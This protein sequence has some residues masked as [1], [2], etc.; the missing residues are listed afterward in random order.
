[1]PELPEVEVVR[2][3]LQEI[4]RDQPILKKIELKRP[5]LRF[6]IPLKKLNSL[7]GEKILSV[8]RRAKYLLLRT[9]KGSLISHL[10]MTGTWRVAPDGDERDHDHVYLHF[11]GSLRLAYRDPRRFGILDFVPFQQQPLQFAHLGPEPLDEAFH[12]DF[13][14]SVLRKKQTAIKVAIMDQRVVVG[15]GNIYACEALFAAGIR[16]QKKASAMTRAQAEVLSQE[17]KRIL[18]QAIADGGSSISDFK[19]TNGSSGYFQTTF[20]VYGRGGEACRSCAQSLRSQVIG[21][22]NSFWCPQC[23]K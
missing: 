4:L 15:V 10:G 1:M 6:P 14:W 5:D 9:S 13:L 22:R 12:G 8:D 21:G 11:S 3:G 18:T 2:K 19:A 7:L 17:I 20:K 16:P 23:Q